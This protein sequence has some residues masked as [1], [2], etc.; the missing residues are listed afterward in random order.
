MDNANSSV[1]PGLCLLLRS[2]AW[3]Q[4]ASSHAQA[5]QDTSL[6]DHGDPVGAMTNQTAPGLWNADSTRSRSRP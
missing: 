3:V 2:V 6:A 1:D 4:G 5:G